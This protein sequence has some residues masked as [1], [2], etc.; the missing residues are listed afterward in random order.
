MDGHGFRNIGPSTGMRPFVFDKGVMGC[1]VGDVNGDGSPDVYIGNGAPMD[2]GNPNGGQ[3]DQLFVSNQSVGGLPKFVDWTPSI[4]FAAPEKQGITYPQ[5][6]YRT[7]GTD[8]VDVDGDGRPEIA[9]A[10]GGPAASPDYVREPDRLFKL[11]L[12]PEPNWLLVHPVGDGEHVSTDAINTRFALTVTDG[13]RTWTVHQTL[14]AAS[15][16]SAQN[17]FDVYFGLSGATSIVSLEVDWPDGTVETITHELRVNERIEVNREDM[18]GTIGTRMGH[19]SHDVV[20]EVAALPPVAPDATAVKLA[21]YPKGAA[22][23]FRCG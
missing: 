20:R 16:F 22:L 4:D 7:H 19:V 14:L 12:D 5:Y 11:G 23:A 17:G 1:Q 6:P 15:C 9:V 10:D 3:V 13:S 18:R 21:S 8:F 2:N